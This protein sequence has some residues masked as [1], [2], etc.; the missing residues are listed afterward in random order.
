MKL[1]IFCAFF[2]FSYN[3]FSQDNINSIYQVNTDTSHAWADASHAVVALDLTGI[4]G[5]RFYVIFDNG[6]QVNLETMLKLPFKPGCNYITCPQ[7]TKNL[8]TVINYMESKGYVLNAAA[9]YH[10]MR[11][12]AQ[13]IFSKK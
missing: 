7:V 2:L 5:N 8:L 1:Y 9:G 3:G 13:Y 12:F 10:D 11:Y 6:N 4:V